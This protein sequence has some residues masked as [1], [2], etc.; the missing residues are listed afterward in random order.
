[1]ATRCCDLVV[2]RL[3][4]SRCSAVRCDKI[5]K[6][7]ESNILAITIRITTIIATIRTPPFSPG[8]PST[9]PPPRPPSSLLFSRVNPTK[10]PFHGRT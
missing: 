8:A 1:M 7:K 5:V 10:F 3:E 4:E 6:T 9:T 2:F